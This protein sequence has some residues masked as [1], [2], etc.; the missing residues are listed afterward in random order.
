MFYAI[1]RV[2]ILRNYEKRLIFVHLAGNDV[3]GYRFHNGTAVITP[4]KIVRGY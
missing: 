2:R 3:S 4:F 1:L